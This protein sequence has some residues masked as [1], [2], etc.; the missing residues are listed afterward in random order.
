MEEGH[1]QAEEEEDLQMVQVELLVRTCRRVDQVEVVYTHRQGGLVE[2]V[3]NLH[4]EDQEEEALRRVGE[5]V[6][7]ERNKK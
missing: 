2:V 5:L 6:N 7:N 3:C 4:Q 1:H